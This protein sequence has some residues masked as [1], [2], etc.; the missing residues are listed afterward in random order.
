MLTPSNPFLF[1]FL[2]HP[3]NVFKKIVFSIYIFICKS[4][5]EA[6][7]N[8]NGAVTL[9]LSNYEKKTKMIRLVGILFLIIIHIV[10]NW[11]WNFLCCD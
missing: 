9:K 10:Q 8:K 2:I 11:S 1:V 5:D 7:F 3:I 6:F 4:F